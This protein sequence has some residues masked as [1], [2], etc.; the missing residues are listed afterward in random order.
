MKRRFTLIELLVVI[1]IIAILASMLLPALSKARKTAQVTKD[2]NA[3]KQIGLATTMYANDASDYI[4]YIPGP[5]DGG[6]NAWGGNGNLY[7][8]IWLF[9]RLFDGKYLPFGNVVT[10]AFSSGVA[11]GTGTAV[12][13]AIADEAQGYWMN[14]MS[15]MT[16]GHHAVIIGFESWGEQAFWS[17]SNGQ[18]ISD[19]PEY[20]ASWTNKPS[21]TQIK[22]AWLYEY[23]AL[24][25]A[26]NSPVVYLDGHAF[27]PARPTVT[28][29]WEWMQ[30]N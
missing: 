22:L 18:R 17:R 13:L 16:A 11:P 6:G 20:A 1:A 3:L 27:N 12:N 8:R 9:N 5:Y 19:P 29:W 30:T 15:N 21:P 10:S 2:L 14:T 23:D 24:A 25:N 4:P 26:N 7:S 28:A